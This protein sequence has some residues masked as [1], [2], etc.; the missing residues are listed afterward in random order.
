[1]GL[2]FRRSIGL[3]P[4][5]RLNLG[6]RSLS[7]SFGIRGAKYTTGTRG[8]QITAGLPG[9]GLSYTKVISSSWRPRRHLFLYLLAILIVI[10]AGFGLLAWLASSSDTRPGSRGQGPHLVR[11]AYAV[12]SYSDIGVTATQKSHNADSTGGSSYV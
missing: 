1:M 5:T 4:G 7:L 8:Q 2:R 9:T 11:P 3:A 12:A 10:G 6:L